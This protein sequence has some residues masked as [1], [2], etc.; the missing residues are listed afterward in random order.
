MVIRLDAK[1]LGWLRKTAKKKGL[2]YQSLVTRSLPGRC[3]RRVSDRK[4]Q[5]FISQMAR[6]RSAVPGL[7]ADRFQ[8]ASVPTDEIILK[9]RSAKIL[10]VNL[11]RIMRR[12]CQNHLLMPND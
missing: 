4:I 6:G 5:K 1:V 8:R 7:T 3:A 2:P 10:G 11:L 12:F 9:Q